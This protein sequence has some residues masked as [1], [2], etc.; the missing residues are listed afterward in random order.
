[1]YF[2]CT[3]YCMFQSILVASTPDTGTVPKRFQVPIHHASF[4][5]A[6]WW[7]L[8]KRAGSE[9]GSVSLV[10]GTDPQIQIRSVPKRQF[11]KHCLKCVPIL[12]I[13]SMLTWKGNDTRGKYIVELV[14]LENMKICLSGK[15]VVDRPSLIQGQN[16]VQGSAHLRASA[17]SSN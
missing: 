10:R 14:H 13:W 5:L 8:T 1:M 9:S 3:S 17:H 11:P 2:W 16:K 4:L 7:S 6:S 15:D 12:S